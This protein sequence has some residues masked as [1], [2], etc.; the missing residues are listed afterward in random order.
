[1]LLKY[2]YAL[3]EG[4]EASIWVVKERILR[5]KHVV[6][7]RW[8]IHKSSCV[9]AHPETGVKVVPCRKVFARKCVV[10]HLIRRHFSRSLLSLN[11][12]PYTLKVSEVISFGIH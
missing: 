2:L 9:S 10:E 4:G 11:P 3:V 6:P 12:P 5:L 8:F 7:Q 1:M